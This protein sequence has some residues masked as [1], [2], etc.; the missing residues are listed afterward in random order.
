M[1]PTYSSWEVTGSG[2]GVP[3]GIKWAVDSPG[4]AYGNGAG[5]PSGGMEGIT[6]AD[7]ICLYV[8]VPCITC[9][10]FINGQ[11]EF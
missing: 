9:I 3:K 8:I 2:R 5:E 4:K 11:S 7:G 1:S 6:A 10:I